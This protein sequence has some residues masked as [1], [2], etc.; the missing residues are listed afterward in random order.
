MFTDRAHCNSTG[1]INTEQTAGKGITFA[2][3]IEVRDP[4]VN[5]QPNSKLTSVLNALKAVKVKT[6]LG[7]FEN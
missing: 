2:L 3:K 1:Q 7:V 5:Q 4:R 6:L